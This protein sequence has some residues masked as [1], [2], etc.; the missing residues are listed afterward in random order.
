MQIQE[1]SSCAWMQ[2]VRAFARSGKSPLC[3]EESCFTRD[4]CEFLVEVGSTCSCNTFVDILCALEAQDLIA[5][6]LQRTRLPPSVEEPKN[7]PF[8]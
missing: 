3:V 6:D 2:P 4:A 7:R 8:C 1:G 5:H